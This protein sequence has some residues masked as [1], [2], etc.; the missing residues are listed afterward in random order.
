[1]FNLL[2]YILFIF[3]INFI[4]KKKKYF[5]SYSGS[6]HQKFINDQV[7]L[8]GGFFLVLPIF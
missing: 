1:M 2:F 4:F 8:T 6:D 7:P 5:S 3:F